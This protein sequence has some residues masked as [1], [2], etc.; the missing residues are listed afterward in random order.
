MKATI[1]IQNLSNVCILK[2]TNTLKILDD[3]SDVCIE[4]EDNSVTFDYSEEHTLNIVKKVLEDIGYPE[5]D[6][7]NSPLKNIN[8]LLSS[9]NENL[10]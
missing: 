9:I 5:I 2:I 1:H 8:S 7:Q 4:I 3:V 10:T 6:K